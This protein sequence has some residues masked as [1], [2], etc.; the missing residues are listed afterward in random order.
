MTLLA[1]SFFLL[2]F[3]ASWV[4]G[5]YVGRGAAAIQAGAI[6]VCGLAA[7]LYG[8]PHVW[9]DNLIWAIVALL[10]Y[11]LIGALI[12]RSGQATRG[13]AK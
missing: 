4:A 1:A 11:G 9:A 3:A 8:M 10:I 2:G 12:F 7:L 6:G 5:R 13:K